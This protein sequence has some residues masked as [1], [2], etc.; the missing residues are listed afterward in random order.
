VFR[1][2]QFHGS[3]RERISGGQALSML[4]DARL[5]GPPGDPSVIAAVG[6][7]E[8]IDRRPTQLT[9]PPAV[10]I[11][12]SARRLVDTS[13]QRGAFWNRPSRPL[14]GASGRGRWSGAARPAICFKG[15]FVSFAMDGA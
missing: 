15:R 14:R 9:A 12:D 1:I 4:A 5:H 6:A 2:D 11:N 8:D 10:Q 13:R 7:K 3:P